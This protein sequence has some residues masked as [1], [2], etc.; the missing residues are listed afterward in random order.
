MT[1]GKI[2]NKQVFMLVLAIGALVCLMVYMLVFTKYNDQTTALKNSNAQL[3]TQVNEMKEYY[4]N[5]EV[6]R[7]SAAEM[8]AGIEEV[9]SD[10]PSDAREEDV[11]MMAV[12]MQNR[13]IINFDA[14]NV[15]E[16][17]VLH[18]IPEEVVKG[19]VVEGMDSAI[20]FV[21]RQATYS[22]TT[23][24][25]NL[26]DAIATVYD[27][28]YRIGVNA[29]A[30][31]KSSDSNNFIEGTIDITYYSVKGMGKEYTVPEMPT[32]FGGA[33]DLFGRLT[34]KQTEE[35]VDMPVEQTQ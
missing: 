23:T 15:E 27:S 12:A 29:V 35:D 4:D 26:K 31:R 17:K 5:M 10:Y 24:Y 3:Q 34:F 30:Y 14:I 2:T 21:E 13:V 32:Y 22:N 6:Y 11:I 9:T 33:S 8:T 28:P 1:I 16:S 18:E 25:S 20:Q 7:T 19:A